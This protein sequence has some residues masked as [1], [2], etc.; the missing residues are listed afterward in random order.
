M[1]SV[2]P[3]ALVCA[4][5]AISPARANMSV[6]NDQA[7]FLAATGATSA[8]G[9]LPSLAGTHHASV[10]IGSVTFQDVNGYGF[11][12]GGLESYTPSDWTTLL[13]G[14]ELAI[15]SVENLDVAFDAPVYSAGFQF[16]EP[17]PQPAANASSPY[18]NN[19]YY[20]FHDSTFT[21][22]LKLNAAVVDSFSFNAPDEVGSFVGAWSDAAFD[23]MEIRET[24]G[25]I[26]DDYFGQFYTGSAAM[27]VPEADTYILMLI[28]IGLVGCA[29]R[30]KCNGQG[31]PP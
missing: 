11:W 8:T 16:A 21:V 13:V 18:A 7:T 29:T 6:F 4:L 10:H 5:M 14:H 26:E 12:V 20:P 1:N 25:A 23:R 27:P 24:S 15:N 19:A 2:F 30:R 22:T 3:A 28:G 9:S 31:I 17:G